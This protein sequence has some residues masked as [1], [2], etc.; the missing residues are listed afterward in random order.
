MVAW[1]RRHECATPGFS[2]AIACIRR[3][4]PC[5]VCRNVERAT[6]GRGMAIAGAPIMTASQALALVPARGA[7][8]YARYAAIN[9][10][11]IS[12]IALSIV[13][14]GGTIGAFGAVA[15]GAMLLAV[16]AGL[17]WLRPIRREIDRHLA[18]CA[19]QA[20]DERRL[21]ELGVVGS[22]RRE[23]YRAVRQLVARLESSAPDEAR[24]FGLQDLLDELVRVVVLHARCESALV[25][26]GELPSETTLA[27]LSPRGRAILGRRAALH[28]RCMRRVEGLAEHADAIEQLV[29]L[30]A[31]HVACTSLD[32]A[33]A[34]DLGDRIDELDRIDDATVELSA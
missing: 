2:T 17:G 4:A 12:V 7:L 11:S 18:Y 34:V 25:A 1:G 23:Q 10:I 19:E 9:P 3:L 8:T 26:G 13:V 16:C 30:V 21:D 29:R 33:C 14:A 20:R 22:V 31:Q 24:R 5:I 27:T 32:E 6:I 15:W 28:A